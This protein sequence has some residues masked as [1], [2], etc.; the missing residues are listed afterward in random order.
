MTTIVGIA[1]GETV[2]MG[3]DSAASSYENCIDIISDTK[4]IIKPVNGTGDQL[5]VG[6][7]GTRLVHE[8]V[9][10]MDF[11]LEPTGE[12]AERE[13][14]RFFVPEIVKVLREHNLLE[15][16]RDVYRGGSM[17]V[18]W[19]GHLFHIDIQ[20]SIIE[21]RIGFRA[22]G[23]GAFYALGSLY[24]T[25]DMGLSPEQRITMAIE[26]AC[27]YD[28]DSLPPIHLCSASRNARSA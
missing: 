25:L 20:L 23:S 16:G 6:M 15:Q 7:S 21:Y 3:C 24:S 8:L 2:W 10:D 11:A 26:A 28:A 13:L 1:D 5:M 14:R 27:Y 12:T 18:G 17:L 9:S 22:A 4:I 19:R